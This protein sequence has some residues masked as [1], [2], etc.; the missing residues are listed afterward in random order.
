MLAGWM[1]VVFHTH[2]TLIY[3]VIGAMKF[4]TIGLWLLFLDS[5]FIF[6]FVFLGSSILGFPCLSLYPLFLCIS[7]LTVLMLR[8]PLLHVISIHVECNFCGLSSTCNAM[9]VDN[10][11]TFVHG[12]VCLLHYLALK[13]NS[14]CFWA[15]IHLCG[16]YSFNHLLHTEIIS[17]R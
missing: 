5:F 7:E 1:D 10:T 4:K 17:S 16:I 8:R 11:N 12:Y 13:F 14:Y 6:G 9:K 15:S 3:I 2:F